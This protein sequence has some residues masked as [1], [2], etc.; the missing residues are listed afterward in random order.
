MWELIKSMLEKTGGAI[1]NGQSRETRNI[2]YTRH[3]MKTNKTKNTSQYAWDTTKLIFL[4]LFFCRLRSR[5]SGDIRVGCRRHPKVL[6]GDS[7]YT[8]LFVCDILN[9]IEL[10]TVLLSICREF[11]FFFCMNNELSSLLF[12]NCLFYAV[13]SIILT[14]VCIQYYLSL[15]FVMK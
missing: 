9:E 3:I 13:N 7:M 11:Y 2:G 5:N 10:G 6:Y 4:F 12:L 15:I 1:K 14:V 8:I